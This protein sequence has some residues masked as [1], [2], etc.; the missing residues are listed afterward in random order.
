METFLLFLLVGVL[1]QSV[2]GALGM[3]YG[4]I[5]NTVLLAFGVPPA[6]ASASVHVAKIFT[7]G[8]SATSHV[9][10]K[11]ILWPLFWP[12]AAGGV[13]GGVLGAYVLTGIEGDRIKPFILAY[14]LVIGVWVLWR[15]TRPTRPRE[16]PPKLSGPLGVVGGF[17]DAIGG[18]GWGPT[19]TSTLVG[20]GADPRRAIGTVNTA[21]LL[22]TS[23]ISAAF[24]VALMTGRWAGGALEDHGA[25]IGGLIVGGLIAAPFAGGITKR[26]PARLLTYAVGILIV[27][28]AAY[29]GLQLAGMVP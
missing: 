5:A 3:A 24:L 4:V 26:I 18:G 20:A 19:V 14:L 13:V 8:A 7:G 25:A 29:Q 2:D 21:E 11:N 12:L 27:T 1:A 6:T 23:A 10:H 28:L 15:A 22:V 17:L 9:M 16:M